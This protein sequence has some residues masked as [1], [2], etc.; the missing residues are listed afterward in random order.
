M[1]VMYTNVYWVYVAVIVAVL[2]KT[3]VVLTVVGI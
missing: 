1:S 3:V 2:E